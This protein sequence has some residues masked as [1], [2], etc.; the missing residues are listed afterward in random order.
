MN[1]KSSRIIRVDMETEVSGDEDWDDAEV[2]QVAAEEFS[3]YLEEKE[4]TLEHLGLG[5]DD[6]TLT[7]NV[8]NHSFNGKV[9]VNCTVEF[10]RGNL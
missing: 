7:R 9:K 4:I 3:A 6:L 1:V 10:N 5:Q 2:W 8:S